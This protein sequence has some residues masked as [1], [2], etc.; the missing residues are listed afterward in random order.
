VANPLNPYTRSPRS[1][2]TQNPDGPV[3]LYIKNGS[4]GKEKEANRLPAPKGSF[5][6]MLR[7]CRPH[8]PPQAAILDGSFT[9]PGVKQGQ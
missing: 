5:M 7:L 1:R 9:P 8:E 4:P 2:F 6:L 3:E